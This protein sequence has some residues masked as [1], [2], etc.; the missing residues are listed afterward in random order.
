VRLE[1]ARLVNASD[2]LRRE[3]VLLA[4]ELDAGDDPID[5]RW[6]DCL[7]MLDSSWERYREFSPVFDDVRRAD[8]FVHTVVYDLLPIRF[9]D[10]WPP[11]AAAWFEGWLRQAIRQS[12]GLVCIS[13]AVADDV[14]AFV[15]AHPSD[16]DSSLRIGF[17]HLG[18]DGA[19]DAPAADSLGDVH[20]GREHAASRGGVGHRP[21]NPPT[22]LMVGTLEPR[23]NHALALSALE[24]LWAEGVDARLC[25]AGKQGWLVEELMTRITTH[26]EL[27]RRL[28][29]LDQATDDA[30]AECYRTSAALLFPSTGEGFGL[31]MIEAAHFGLPIIASDLPVFREIAGDHATYVTLGDAQALADALRAWLGGDHADPARQSGLIDALT[32]EQSAEQLLDVVL[33]NRWY[34]R[35]DAPTS[36]ARAEELR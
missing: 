14:R 26:P 36:D 31:P 7:L 20:S 28:R 9:P 33:E 5:I 23:K 3:N 29:Y 27:G 6:G 13:R 4:S 18:R 21:E 8:G 24:I 32:W 15:D 1:G 34:W 10:F 19:P 12:D 25:I 11:G 22:F 16:T 35:S 30:L 2:W 17:W